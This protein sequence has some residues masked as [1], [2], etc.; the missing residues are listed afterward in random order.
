M[1]RLLLLLGIVGL[2]GS[3]VKE[4]TQ[5]L[6][7]PEICDFGQL[8]D[9]SFPEIESAR[10]G[11]RSRDRD[12]DGVADQYDNCPSVVNPDQLDSDG[13]GIGDVCDA[14]PYPPGPTTKPVIFLDFDG[15][16][17]P[18]GTAWNSG[19]TFECLPS[20]L[21]PADINTVIENV[22]H[23][24]RNFNVLITADSVTFLKADKAK[25]IRVVLTTSSDVYYQPVAGVAYVGSMFWGDDTPCFVFTNRTYYDAKR[26]YVTAAHE[27][28]HTIGLYH[29]AN[30]D[31]NCV[32]LSSYRSCN[33]STGLGPIMGNAVSC[34]P[35]W[36]VGPTPNGCNS[37]QNDSLLMVSKLK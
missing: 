32:L 2:F 25:R 12:K 24:Y 30:W 1:K 4:Q 36:W 26:S 22:V 33:L 14:T 23:S 5:R 17:L 9:V 29:Q 20:G 37:I 27:A 10:A 6:Q 34:L 28:G 11:G 3:C 31:V 7:S 16:T 21:L 8:S 19:A 15:Y 18:S 35:L 13:D